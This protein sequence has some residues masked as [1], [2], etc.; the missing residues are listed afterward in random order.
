MTDFSYERQTVRQ[1]KTT[2]LD[3][4]RRPLSVSSVT[5]T[6]QTTDEGCRLRSN[7]VRMTS[8]SL[9]WHEYVASWLVSLS[10]R[11]FVDVIMTPMTSRQHSYD[12]VCE[13]E[14]MSMTTKRRH[15]R[16][17]DVDV[18]TTTSTMTRRLCI[19]V[20][21]ST[22]SWHSRREITTKSTMQWRQ[23]RSHD[24]T[25]TSTSRQRR[26]RHCH[27]I[28]VTLSW[29]SSSS[30]R[31]RC[32]R[33]VVVERHR[34]DENNDSMTMTSFRHRYN[35]ATMTRGRRARRQSHACMGGWPVARHS[36]WPI[37]RPV[38]F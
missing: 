21:M 9:Q 24:V 14:M 26:W 10:R 29:T 37:V 5:T 19:I 25:T 7:D 12:D 36:V 35:D 34:V 17:D 20:M 18:V 8:T 2:T 31:R 30:R 38:V 11:R 15:Q 6:S 22:S 16:H 13:A 33:R 32:L 1:R 28:T 27:E 3:V 4:Q 23:C